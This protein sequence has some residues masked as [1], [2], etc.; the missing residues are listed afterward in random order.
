MLCSEEDGKKFGQVP[1]LVLIFVENYVMRCSLLVPKAV[2]I[3]Q[4]AAGGREGKA[5]SS[6]EDRK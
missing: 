3:L 2:D 1:M 5:E 6:R 4:P